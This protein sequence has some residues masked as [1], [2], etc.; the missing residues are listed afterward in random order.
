M[1]TVTAKLN[2]YHQS[3]RKVRLLADLVRGRRVDDAL[4]QLR[5]SKRRGAAALA[6]LIRSGIANAR[7][8]ITAGSPES[9][10]YID[11]IT[12]DEGPTLK[13]IRPRAR[14][15]ASPIRKRT[16]HVFVSL[17]DTQHE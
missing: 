7:E 11:R 6:K 8:R 14:G 13:R 10:L 3:P 16:S 15:S 4:V 5:F 1:T 2:H 9:V 12:V 17:T